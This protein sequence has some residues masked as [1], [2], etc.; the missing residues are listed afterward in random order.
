[1]CL[2]RNINIIVQIILRFFTDKSV[3][4]C[5]HEANICQW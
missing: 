1:M 4:L 5:V 2:K 3:Q